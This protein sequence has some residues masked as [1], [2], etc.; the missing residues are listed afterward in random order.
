[1]KILIAAIILIPALLFGSIVMLLDNPDYYQDELS[2]IVK[3]QTG[4]E[5]AI[6]GDIK[7]RYWPLIAINIT[8]VELRPVDA[9]DALMT[10]DSVAVDLKLLPLIFGAELAIDGLSIDGLTVNAVVDADGSGN[11]EVAGNSTETQAVAE[12]GDSSSVKLDIAGINI[13]NANISYEELA[14][15]SHYVIAIKSLNSGAISYN[16]LTRIDFDIVIEDKPAKLRSVITGGGELAFDATLNKYQFKQLTINT[17]TSMPDMDNIP[18]SLTLSGNAD[19]L[20]GTLK[21]TDSNFNVADMRG[22]TSLDVTDLNGAPTLQGKLQIMPFAIK[23]FMASL[24]LDPIATNNP[25]ALNSFGLTTDISGTL[26]I[27]S[28]TNLTAMLDSSNIKGSLTADTGEKI[29][30]G[31]DIAID[32]I[33]LSD[34][35]SPDVA[36]AEAETAVAAI[37]SEVLPVTLFNTYELDGKLSIDSILYD[38][39]ILNN[40]VTT[41]AN[42]QQKLALSTT[43][44]GY[45]GR[46]SLNFD[47]NTPVTGV[48]TGATKLSIK[49]LSITKL[50][51]FEWITGNLDLDSQTTFKGKMLS[52]ILATLDGDNRFTINDGTL[53]VR[54]IK[55]ATTML[56]S[57]RGKTSSVA[58]WPDKMPF[59]SLNGNLALNAG[60]EANQQLNVQLET[61]LIGGTGGVDYWNNQLVYDIGIT[62][63]ASDTSQFG[64]KPPMAGLRWPLHCEGAIDASPVELCLPN[65]K[66]V[67]KLV[68]DL[69]TQEVQRQGTD[70]IVEKL[71]N[72][73][74]PEIQDKAKNLLK[75]LFGK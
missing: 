64:V 31:F 67:Q 3:T 4:F 33:N 35:M 58:A 17:Q 73:L 44:D 14:T 37:D 21:L 8:G 26:P 75:G 60:I 53:D 57:L 48:A 30:A 19:L 74:S 32:Q 72:Q 11:W 63:Q 62:L 34:Y 49:G 42:R 47:A 59:E 2:S 43:V 18:A 51:E 24:K 6:N 23:P 9:A 70:K 39:Y 54:P 38:A 10:L 65:L 41:I 25:D 27:I 13:S 56:D 55:S 36:P 16:K 45:D 29:K 71:Q 40:F 1:M 50:T 61:M 20:V 5:V 28:F 15:A 69:L 52:E 46:I 12:D 66:G 22:S 7:W 68:A